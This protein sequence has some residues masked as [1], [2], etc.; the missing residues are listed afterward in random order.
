[1]QIFADKK[2]ENPIEIIEA[3]DE[4][5]FVVAFDKIEKYRES[6]YLLGYIRYEAKDIFLKKKIK[7]KFPLLYFEVFETFEK[8][9]S[10]KNPHSA[11]IK[12]EAQIDYD[13]YKKAIENIRENIACGNTYQV[14]YTYDYK[15]TSNIE[16]QKLY[17]SI[18]TNQ[19][20]PYNAYIKN[21]YEEILSFSPELF[22]ELE[23]N[24]IKTKPM[25]G[26]VKRGKTEKE[27]KKNIEF[28]KND[29]KNRAENVMIVDLLRNDLG[30]IAKTGT[31][32]V[33]KL[34]EVETHKTVHQMTSEITA[35]LNENTSMLEIFEA[36]FPCGSIT[37]AP[38]IN[39]MNIIEDAEV[40]S[41]EVYC[42]AI[43]LIS[44]EKTVFS[45][46]I[47]ILHRKENED[48][49]KCRVG[50]AIVWDST[51]EDEWQET[52]TKIKFLE[53]DFK[54]IETILVKNNKMKY[55]SL[56]MKRLK[57]SAKELSFNFNKDILK[58]KPE[59]DGIMR[60]LLSKDGL[61]ETQYSPLDPVKTNKVTISKVPVDRKNKFLYHKTTY[62]P[63]YEKS[64]ERIK[65]GEIFD[66]I[67]L[68]EKGE[69]TEGSR[70]NI[71]LKING[72]LFTPSV[73]CGL[74]NGVMRQ[75]LLKNTP[76][77]SSRTSFGIYPKY[78]IGKML[79]QVQHDSI[80]IIKEKKLYLDDLK[81]AEKIYCINSVRGIVEVKLYKSFRMNNESEV[82]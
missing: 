38:K 4:K 44:P 26:T 58:I 25:K 8:Y 34:F 13:T 66:E 45:V 14:N 63:W 64:L 22:F 29:E 55:K 62:R 61:F 21:H 36:I 30:K 33:D 5:S 42:G 65:N 18:L 28:L 2:F 7:S 43:G 56:H 11:L 79:K 71:V 60:I 20:T 72:E 31:V 50:G 54:L 40:G 6:H 39:T 23:N 82:G 80:N 74:L 77:L 47:R 49:Y 81:Q 75:N 41:R 15:I 51:P 68:N 12:K 57:Q 1:M 17:E 19:T 76:D 67:F 48:F 27:D 35:E 52:L 10:G 46:P 59:K 69:L 3:F 78:N 53:P 16:G 73:E 70:S 32:K 24:T 9:S 37:G